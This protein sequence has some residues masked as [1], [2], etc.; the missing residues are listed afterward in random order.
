VKGANMGRDKNVREGGCVYSG[1]IG[2]IR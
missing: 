1:L 2:C